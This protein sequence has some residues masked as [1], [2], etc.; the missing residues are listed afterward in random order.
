M[1]KMWPKESSVQ[2]KIEA[3]V[4]TLLAQQGSMH[5]KRYLIFCV[6]GI[7]MFYCN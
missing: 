7:F 3:T 4:S 2:K 6:D 1:E 5:C